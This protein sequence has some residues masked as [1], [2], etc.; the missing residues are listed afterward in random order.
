MKLSSELLA[1]ATGVCLYLE[2]INATTAV[3]HVPKREAAVSNAPI[4]SSHDR[5]S[6]S[7]FT[8]AFL[9]SFDQSSGG[10]RTE[11][12]NSKKY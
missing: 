11:V 1:L 5:N 10:H 12:M 6:A 3:M 4:I 2:K 8:Q 7:F 9:P